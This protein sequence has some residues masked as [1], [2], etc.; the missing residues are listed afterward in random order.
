MPIERRVSS[1][2]SSVH[3]HP[4][5]DRD[6]SNMYFNNWIFSR[7]EW[8]LVLS[9]DWLDGHASRNDVKS[10]IVSTSSS[11]P[12]FLNMATCGRGFDKSVI[13]VRRR[14][15]GHALCFDLKVGHALYFDSKVEGFVT[16]SSRLPQRRVLYWNW[17]CLARLFRLVCPL[18][19]PVQPSFSL[20]AARSASRPRS[21]C[22]QPTQ[23]L[24]KSIIVF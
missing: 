2:T 19:A 24:Q 5:N 8:L 18:R 22:D 23:D 15:F 6:C 16:G 21:G 12:E 11:Y 7:D 14:E 1:S 10:W 17:K 4:R 9:V 13:P 3:Q 20:A